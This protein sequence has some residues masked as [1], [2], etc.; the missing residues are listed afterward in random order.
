VRRIF[1]YPI[2]IEESFDL[3]L[4]LWARVLTVQT[5]S[6]TVLDSLIVAKPFIWALASDDAPPGSPRHFRLVATG[7]S[8][9]SP[10]ESGP[11]HWIYIGTFQIQIPEPRNI[12]MGD[13]PSLVFHLFEVLP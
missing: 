12:K 2:P 13:S 8:F 6:V 5:Q 7:E 11:D 9:E 3:E 1:K 10:A 4:P